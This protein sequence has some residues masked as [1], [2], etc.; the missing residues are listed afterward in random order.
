M[1][2]EYVYDGKRI[3]AAYTHRVI[4]VADRVGRIHLGVW[5][6]YNDERFSVGLTVDLEATKRK[7]SLLVPCPI[8]S[9]TEFGLRGCFTKGYDEPACAAMER[10]DGKTRFFLVLYKDEKLME[11]VPVSYRRAV[12]RC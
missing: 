4:P 7:G 12:G 6:S 3:S 9:Y 8:I 5:G 11:L 10:V 1:V 2:I